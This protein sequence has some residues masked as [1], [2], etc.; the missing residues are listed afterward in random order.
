[1]WELRHFSWLLTFRLIKKRRNFTFQQP[2]AASVDVL[3]IGFS[4]ETKS[5]LLMMLSYQLYPLIPTYRD[6]CTIE[7][8]I[9]KKQKSWNIERKRGALGM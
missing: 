6:D 4:G 1:M 5:A 8:N 7:Q 9:L 2:K 3:H